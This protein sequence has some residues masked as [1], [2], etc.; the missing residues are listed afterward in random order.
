MRAPRGITPDPR[1][2]YPQVLLDD[3]LKR[4][5]ITG[6]DKWHAIVEDIRQ[7]PAYKAPPTPLHVVLGDIQTHKQV[8]RQVGFVDVE[9]FNFTV[10]HVWTVDSIVGHQFSSSGYSPRILGDRAEAFEA[11]LRREL[12]AC[13]PSGHYPDILEF[14]Y[15]LARRPRR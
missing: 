8:F 12:L 5:G 2:P 14:G 6:K 1:P 9:D 7:R 10:K 15:T 11:D 4:A 13:D 3:L